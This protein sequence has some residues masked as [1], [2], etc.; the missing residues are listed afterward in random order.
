L[1]VILDNFRSRA[2]GGPQAKFREDVTESGEPVTIITSLITNKSIDTYGTHMSEDSIEAISKARNINLLDSHNHKT[3]GYG[4]STR[5]W[6]DGDNVYG[7]F[8][9]LHKARWSDLMT[10][11]KAKDL[12][13]ELR[14]R[15]GWDTSLGFGNDFDICDLC[16][17]IDSKERDIW[18]DEDCEHWL[19]EFYPVEGEDEKVKATAELRGAE[20]YENSLV[21]AGANSYS[22]IISQAQREIVIEKSAHLLKKGAISTESLLRSAKIFRIPELRTVGKPSRDKAFIPDKKRSKPTMPKTTEALE[23][24]V[25]A[26][27][28]ELE[29]ATEAKDDMKELYDKEKKAHKALKAEVKNLRAELATLEEL[30][31]G[32]RDNCVKVSDEADKLRDE[33][34]R[35][36]DDEKTELDD[37]L[38]EMSYRDLKRTLS[39]LTKERDILVALNEREFGEGDDPEIPDGDDTDNPKQPAVRGELDSRFTT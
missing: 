26:L 29:E 27:E 22:H 36:T 14:H 7:D 30:K 4:V 5:I 6:R 24:R 16:V 11:T 13:Y 20:I 10:Y 35:L 31:E 33:A 39:R 21:F 19:G 32:L 17:K 25:E 23:S 37:D 8:A 1:E 9:I 3:T 28:E 15:P 18:M 12:L 2:V 34:D 38:K